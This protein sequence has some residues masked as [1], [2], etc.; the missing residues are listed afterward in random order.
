[1]IPEITQEIN[2]VVVEFNRGMKAFVQ[3]FTDKTKE[4]LRGFNS[5]IETHFSEVGNRQSNM[6]G[7]SLGA[8]SASYR[9]AQASREFTEQM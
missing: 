2:K 5:E 9:K 1:M 8:N 3:E 4:K 7:Q 6:V